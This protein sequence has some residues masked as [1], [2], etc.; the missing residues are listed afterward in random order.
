MIFLFYSAVT[1]RKKISNEIFILS[2]RLYVWVM[3]ILIR[4][5]VISYYRQFMCEAFFFEGAFK[6][7]SLIHFFFVPITTVP[8][9]RF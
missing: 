4:V 9:S 1:S 2:N 5:K 3:K 8:F 6:F 7:I